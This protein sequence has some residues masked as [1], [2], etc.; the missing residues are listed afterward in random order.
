MTTTFK[1]QIRTNGIFVVFTPKKVLES[2]T[3][4]W[5][6]VLSHLALDGQL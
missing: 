3:F 4:L 6:M 1:A 5:L 2:L